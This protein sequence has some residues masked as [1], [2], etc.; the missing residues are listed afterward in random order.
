MD[1][2]E[3]IDGSDTEDSTPYNEMSMTR[4]SLGSLGSDADYD[5]ELGVPGSIK[6]L[7]MG[8][9]PVAIE[10]SDDDLEGR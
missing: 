5:D 8:D 9:G 6:L 7:D 3:N 10:N 4:P 1:T 2:R